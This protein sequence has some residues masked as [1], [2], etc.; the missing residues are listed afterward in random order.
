MCYGRAQYN[1]DNITAIIITR[2]VSAAR[3]RKSSNRARRVTARKDRAVPSARD[4]SVSRRSG[5]SSSVRRELRGGRVGDGNRAE[6]LGLQLF[7][8]YP[9][10]F[11]RTCTVSTRQNSSTPPAV[12]VVRFSR[13]QNRRGSLSFRFGFRRVVRGRSV[14]GK[15]KKYNIV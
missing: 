14:L 2:L 13:I 3:P 8:A 4:F 1:S 5:P 7:S 15:K 9:G 12:L 11:R 6:I 10:V